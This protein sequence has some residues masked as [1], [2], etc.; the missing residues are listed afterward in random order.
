[1]DKRNQPDQPDP[2]STKN[3]PNQHTLHGSKLHLEQSSSQNEMK[4]VA[5]FCRKLRLAEVRYIKYNEDE[6]LVGN[7]SNSTLSKGRTKICCHFYEH[8]NK[9]SY[10]HPHKHNY[11]PNFRKAESP[12]VKILKDDRTI[13]INQRG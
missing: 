2:Q 5:E 11:K 4:D 3:R 12:E 6:S 8:I 13:T 7:K 1:M 9:Y 10:Q